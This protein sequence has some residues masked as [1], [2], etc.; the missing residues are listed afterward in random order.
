MGYLQGGCCQAIAEGQGDFFNIAPALT[1]GKA[2]GTL[3]GKTDARGLTET[4][5]TI[6]IQYG[7]M[8]KGLRHFG[9]ANLTGFF[10]DP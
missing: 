3:A 6:H 2:A 10:D 1:I 9:D 7:F 5:T 8:A 4:K